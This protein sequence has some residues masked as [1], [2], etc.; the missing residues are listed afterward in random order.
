VVVGFFH[1]V[2]WVGVNRSEALSFERFDRMLTDN[3]LWTD[4]RIAAGSEVLASFLVERDAL[5]DA[6]KHLERAVGFAPRKARYWHELGAAY[7][8]LGRLEDAEKPLRRAVRL[9]RKDAQAYTSLGEIYIRQGRHS[10]AETALKRA[11]EI[12]PTRALT[13][14]YLGLLYRDVGAA[15]ES[16]KA[17]QRATELRP[18]LIGYWHHLAMALEQVP[19]RT[20]E[21]IKAWRRVVL[22]GRVNPLLEELVREA[23]ERIEELRQLEPRQGP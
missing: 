22:I 1:V 3:P 4:K 6:V 11:L 13:H 17:F 9:D 20:G 16:V 8:L 19:G 7:L 15:E 23:E 18:S 5:E 14:F 2:P 12:D 21:A 10:E